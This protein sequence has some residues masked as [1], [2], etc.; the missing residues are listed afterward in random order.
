M[1]KNNN[2]LSLKKA[3]MGNSPK[4]VD[5]INPYLKSA[6]KTNGKV[7]KSFSLFVKT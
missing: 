4:L 7:T 2:I 3:S 1:P 5:E 6:I